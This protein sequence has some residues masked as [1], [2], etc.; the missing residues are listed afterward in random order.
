MGKPIATVSTSSPALS[1]RLPNLGDVR[2]LKAQRFALDPLL[3]NR[4]DLAPTKSANCF[5][6]SLVCF[7]AVNHPSRLESTKETKSSGERTFPDTG[8]GVSPATN[9]LLPS[10]CLA[11]SDVRS[12]IL[13]LSTSVSFAINLPTALRVQYPTLLQTYSRTSAHSRGPF[14]QIQDPA[15]SAS[16]IIKK[17]LFDLSNFSP[18]T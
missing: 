4:A 10:E 7:P 15:S 17:N 13:P 2:P 12:R 1:A 6:K 18:R 8:T 14:V 9:S 16:N 3:T 11:N 5:S